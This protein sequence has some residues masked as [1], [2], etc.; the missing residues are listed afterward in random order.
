MGRAVAKRFAREHDV[1]VATW[2]GPNGETD[3]AKGVT[4]IDHTRPA[5]L[6]GLVDGVDAIIY[7]V[8]YGSERSDEEEAWT[9][10]RSTLAPFRLL[11]AARQ[12]GVS[13]VVLG[14]TLRFF[15]AYPKDC[16]IDEQW[17]PRPQPEA[18]ALAPY[19]CEQ[20]CREFAREGPMAVVA[21]RFD[22]SEVENDASAAISAIEKA[23][24]LQMTVPGYRWQVFHIAKSDRYLTRQARTRLGLAV[25]KEEGC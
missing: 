5:D 13:R 23:L 12:R 3:A 18:R 4:V 2:A 16:V 21:L 22:S 17:M 7:L 8:E 19:L 10:L 9:I 20:T 25:R 24:A 6:E 15:D 11:Q 1:R 14:S